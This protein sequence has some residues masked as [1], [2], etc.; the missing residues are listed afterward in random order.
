MTKKTVRVEGHWRYNKDG[1]RT[2]VKSHT[3]EQPSSFSKGKM[4]MKCGNCGVQFAH[5][6]DWKKH[7]ERTGHKEC[8]PIKYAN[9][10]K[11]E[12]WEK[13]KKYSK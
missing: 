9:I 3:R 7:S 1:T 12:N 11:K 2:W 10:K 5:Y 13:L 4:S 6:K 8:D